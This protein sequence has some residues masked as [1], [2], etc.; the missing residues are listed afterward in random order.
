MTHRNPSKVGDDRKAVDRAHVDDLMRLNITN[1][2]PAPAPPA[3]PPERQPMPDAEE[4]ADDDDPPLDNPRAI[5]EQPMDEI[6]HGLSDSPSG[7]DSDFE[8]REVNNYPSE[9]SDERE[10]S[11]DD[12]YPW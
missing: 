2:R 1:F 9:Y 8:A 6:Y 3:P 7:S 4:D 10:P 5:N 12:A 11:E